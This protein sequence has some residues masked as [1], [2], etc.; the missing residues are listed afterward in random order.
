MRAR[1]SASCLCAAVTPWHVIRSDV[2]Q[3]EGQAYRFVA[4][5]DDSRAVLVGGCRTEKCV[6]GMFAKNGGALEA[7]WCGAACADRQQSGG[8]A[9]QSIRMRDGQSKGSS[10]AVAADKQ[11]RQ[12]ARQRSRF[13]DCRGQEERM[14]MGCAAEIWD[15]KAS[16]GPG[17]IKAVC[18]QR[19]GE[20]AGGTGAD[21]VPNRSQ[22][23]AGGW[24]LAA[25]QG[26]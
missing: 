14:G 2:G 4:R 22:L 19:G 7:A 20:V 12:R 5:H 13:V 17:S 24:R 3:L 9:Q 25:A 18:Q 11:R 26:R 23:A 8:R 15:L 16:A 6:A 1:R 10:V 21:R